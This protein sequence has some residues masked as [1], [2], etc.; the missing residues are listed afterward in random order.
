MLILTFKKE[1]CYED[2][3]INRN[4]ADLK[5]F[6]RA[7]TQKEGVYCIPGFIGIDFKVL[8]L[9]IDLSKETSV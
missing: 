7:L 4:L 8:H 1:G 2:Y 3:N 5:A 6:E 9:E